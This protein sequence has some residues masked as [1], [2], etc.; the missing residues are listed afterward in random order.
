MAVSQRQP[1]GILQQYGSMG[2]RAWMHCKIIG[3]HG[4]HHVPQAKLKQT[5]QLK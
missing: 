3:G 4:R 1:V 2:A 5:A